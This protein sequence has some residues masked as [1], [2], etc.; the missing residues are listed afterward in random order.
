MLD[1]KY[2]IFETIAASHIM[3]GILDLYKVIFDTRNYL[4]IKI[5]DKKGLLFNIALDDTKIIGFKIG[6]EIDKNKFYSWLGG[7]D[8]KL[9]R[10]ELTR[11]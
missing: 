2:Y 4:P 3:S 8:P 5:K 11:C 1:I 7:V 6:Y 9:L 10:G